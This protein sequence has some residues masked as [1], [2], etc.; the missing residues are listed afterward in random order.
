MSLKTPESPPVNND[1]QALWDAINRLTE[2]MDKVFY[3]ALT[4]LAGVIGVLV[5]VLMK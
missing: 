5:A 2:R 3:V 1:H 4:M